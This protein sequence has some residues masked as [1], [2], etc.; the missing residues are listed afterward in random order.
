MDSVLFPPTQAS[1][2][3]RGYPLVYAAFSCGMGLA[4]ATARRGT[5]GLYLRVNPRSGRLPSLRYMDLRDPQG[6]MWSKLLHTDL[7]DIV[8]TGSVEHSMAMLVWTI[9]AKLYSF[10]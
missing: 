9:V 2:L 6:R 1:L 4:S 7:F 5:A 8:K 3:W 10:K